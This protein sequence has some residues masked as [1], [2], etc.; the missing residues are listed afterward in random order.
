MQ[1]SSDDPV[2]AVLL[3]LGAVVTELF[4]ARDLLRAETPYAALRTQF[5][6]LK[7]RWYGGS[8]HI[9]PAEAD[10]VDDEG[11]AAL[12]RL[13]TRFCQDVLITNQ[14]AEGEFHVMRV[15]IG[16]INNRRPRTTTLQCRSTTIRHTQSITVLCNRRVLCNGPDVPEHELRH[17]RRASH[18]ADGRMD[19]P[20]HHDCGRGILVRRAGGAPLAYRL[21]RTRQS[22]PALG[23]EGEGL[24]RVY[25]AMYGTLALGAASGVTFVRPSL[26]M[27]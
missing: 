5:N 16:S 22:R 13:R 10:Q 27:I 17:P 18:R 26:L 12:L 23:V 24:A 20:G 1:S 6:F 21:H 15:S 4:E 14:M 11:E 25:L 9:T 3:E 19:E 2:L 8:A 7:S